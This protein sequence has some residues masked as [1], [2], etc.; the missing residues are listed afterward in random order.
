MTA[1][2]IAKVTATKLENKYPMDITQHI[3]ENFIGVECAEVGDVSR[4]R[5]VFW[6]DN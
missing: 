5:F 1:E 6:F 2:E 3:C 4:T